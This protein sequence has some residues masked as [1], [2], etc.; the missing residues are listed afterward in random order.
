MAFK[1]PIITAQD[2]DG[3]VSEGQNKASK[4]EA[5]IVD[6]YVYEENIYFVFIVVSDF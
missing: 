5:E 6:D 4:D 1:N 2:L 3:T